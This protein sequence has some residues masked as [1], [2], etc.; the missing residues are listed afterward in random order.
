LD[1]A[2]SVLLASKSAGPNAPNPA[3]DDDLKVIGKYPKRG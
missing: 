2:S 3:G 1:P